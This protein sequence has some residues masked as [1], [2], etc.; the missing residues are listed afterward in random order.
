MDRLIKSF[1]IYM[2]VLTSDNKYTQFYLLIN[3]RMDSFHIS[4]IQKIMKLSM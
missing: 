2:Y 1:N 4:C 3:L